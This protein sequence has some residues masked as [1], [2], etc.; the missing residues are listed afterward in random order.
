LVGLADQVKLE[1]G[2]GVLVLGELLVDLLLDLNGPREV[3]F[4]DRDIVVRLFIF[5]L[6]LLGLLREVVEDDRG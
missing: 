3:F 2:L 1:Q 6:L 5:L 4:A